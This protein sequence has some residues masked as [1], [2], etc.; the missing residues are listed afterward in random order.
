MKLK[1]D[2]IPIETGG[3]AD[4]GE[5]RIKASATAFG[6][7][8]SG[9]YSN[10][11]KAILRELGCNA[12]DSHVEAGYPER[13]FTVHLPT[14]LNPVLSIR[15]YGVGLDHEQVMG[16]YTTYFESTKNDSNDFVGCMGLGSKSPFSY[17]KNF[18]IVAI[19]NGIKGTYSAFIGKNGVP[20]VAQ[21]TSEETDEESG[22]E[23]SFAVE[24]TYDMRNFKHEVNDTYKWFKTKPEITGDAVEIDDVDYSERDIA[25]GVHMR[26]NQGYR[27]RSY[28]LMGNVAYPINVPEGE[29]LGKGVRELLHNN[30][31]VI[32]V[33]IGEL[34]IA[35]SREELGYTDLTI[36][37]LK[38]KAEVIFGA[39][40]SYVDTQLA[41]A[42]TKWDRVI[43]A[44]KLISSNSN[45][46]SEIVQKYAKKNPRK[47][48]KGLL[49]NYHGMNVQVPV[50][51]FEK[52]VEGMRVTQ[53]NIQNKSYNSNPTKLG[54][55][56][57]DHVLKPGKKQVTS[58]YNRNENDY[59]DVHTIMVGK[60][61]IVFN[62]EPGNVLARIRAACD[63][64]DSTELDGFSNLLIVKAQ[65]KQCDKNA[66]LKFL[67]SRL[68]GM[69]LVLA[70]QL[71]SVTG[72]SA[73]ATGNVKITVQEFTK[74]Q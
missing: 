29:E 4:Q 13:P 21:L 40:E 68:P 11:F 49:S 5:F 24:E 51:E 46:F 16:L 50:S 62:D 3:L 25:P 14:R 37:T 15:D 20:N 35:A 1:H 6:I 43:A 56:K 67:K 31:F 30:A 57:P 33:N 47:F 69:P 10:K 28:A 54:Q 26:K 41:P 34:D 66:M 19:K 23:I 70:S 61:A 38:K 48:P 32:E 55:I 39:L 9:L 8:S 27:N 2:D 22:V 52:A 58:Y 65:N 53:K 60:T 64:D 36:E 71:P 74:K 73:G 42:K 45:L 59:W 18:T 17:T 12:Y 44:N 63:D 72:L 7:L